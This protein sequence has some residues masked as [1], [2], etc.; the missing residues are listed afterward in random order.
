MEQSSLLSQFV[1]YKKWSVVNMFPDSLGKAQ[2]YNY[3]FG[4]VQVIYIQIPSRFEISILGLW[5]K[6]L[7]PN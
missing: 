7:P 3:F 5:G 4:I 1:S 2:I 6:S